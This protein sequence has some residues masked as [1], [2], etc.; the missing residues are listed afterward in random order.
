M[1][2]TS[3]F[4]G[5]EKR[6]VKK[7]RKRIARSSKATIV[8][9]AEEADDDVYAGIGAT[10]IDPDKERDV[11]P[12]LPSKITFPDYATFNGPGSKATAPL[13]PLQTLFA[14]VN[15]SSDVTGQ[16]ID[17][18]NVDICLPCP[19]IELFPQP[20]GKSYLP[21][22]GPLQDS[23]EAYYAD[24]Q[25]GHPLAIKA[26]KRKDFAERLAELEVDND[27]GYRTITRSTK[28]GIKR[29]RLAHMRKFWAGLETMSHYW[30]CTLDQ[31]YELPQLNELEYKA[32]RQRL[33][34]P[35]DVATHT[36]RDPSLE[37]ASQINRL[38]PDVAAGVEGN[39]GCEAAPGAKHGS[40]D[41]VTP[42]H[43]GSPTAK[44][45]FAS[46][47]RYKGRRTKTGKEMPDQFRTN[48][49]KAF[50]E[51]SIWPFHYSLSVPRVAPIVQ[52]GKLN[53][54]V[55][56]TAA[57]YRLPTEKAKARSGRL[58]GPVVAVQ[59]RAGIEL[60]ES[61]HMTDEA[62]GRLDV[63]RE[64]GGLLQIAQERRHEGKTEVKPG[65]GKWYTT[66]PRWGG[67]PGAETE[68]GDRNE[69]VVQVAEEV[70]SSIRAPKDKHNSRPRRKTNEMLWQEL[71]CGSGLWDPKTD[72]I[73]IGKDVGTPYDE[74]FMVSSLYHHISIV[75]L[76]T[77][78]AYTDYLITGQTPDPL[79][80]DSSWCR[81]KLQRSEWFDLFDIKQRVEAF[82]GLWA[83]MA[84]LTRET[85]SATAQQHPGAD[86]DMA[87]TS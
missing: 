16:H 80:T 20:D 50:V 7:L 47:K 9:S 34:S 23:G 79:P 57:I 11:L 54:P 33:D 66:T 62:R 26:K 45:Y 1:A 78:D 43:S 48:T 32:K 4:V 10:F 31:Y 77:H 2:R 14:R 74:I 27:T 63:M 21:P 59:A 3:W 52:F 15:K 36:N 73:A 81:P 24:L 41:R 65:E 69:E 17:A 46:R 40:D 76:T 37:A 30:D 25:P 64:I 51:G 38:I 19:L 39:M 83:V 71:R 82:R 49:V 53:V 56:Q 6:R 13:P 70:L 18:L 61:P 42:S 87:G 85:A 60:P 12:A 72:Y 8:N 29:P 75:K 86:T 84:Y 22:V 5:S 35:V 44:A 58:E 67:G 55:K 28:D 68:A